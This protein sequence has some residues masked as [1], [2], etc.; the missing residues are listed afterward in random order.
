MFDEERVGA[1]TMAAFIGAVILGGGN[2]LAV[3]ISNQELP[4]FWGAGLRF[5]IAGLVFV[6]IALSLRLRWPRGRQAL[7]IAIYG[8]V[9]FSL[10]YALMYWALVRVT[11]GMVAVL[12]AVVP[13]VTPILAATHRVERL[14]RRNLLG[15]LVA[16]GGIV[17]MTVGPE[18]LLMPLGGLTAV[19]IAA[20]TIG[21]S[22]IIGKRVSVNHP[23]MTNAIAMPVGSI[24]LLVISA[25]AGEQWATPH[26]SE[27][28]WSLV[29][30][31]A[32]GS[33]GLFVL[34]LLVVRKWTASGTAYAF[35]LFP[36]VTLLLEALLFDE[37]LSPRAILG[38]IVVMGAVW[39]GALAQPAKVRVG[40]APDPATG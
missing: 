13:L 3:R 34:F 17:V 14:S 40:A 12:L 35:V 15:A 10:S 6:G 22:V 39:F 4:P 2:F 37:A 26:Q 8:L 7:L 30:L 24:G 32:L 23:A 25:L 5:G 18:G 27:V 21:E 16:L 29:Y 36:V 38:A 1:S 11:A 19:G 20:V 33:V 31:V 28:I 9:S